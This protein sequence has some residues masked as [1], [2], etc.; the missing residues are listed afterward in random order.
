[1]L[2][3]MLHIFIL[4]R[5][6]RT[7]GYIYINCLWNLLFFGLLHCNLYIHLLLCM[8]NNGNDK[9]DIVR[10]SCRTNVACKHNLYCL[11]IFEL[12]CCILCNLMSSRNMSGN[13]IRK[14]GR[15][16]C[17]GYHHRNGRCIYRDNLYRMSSCLLASHS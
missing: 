9:V 16:D 13:Y 15:A 2:V 1:M 11:S 5:H 7:W 10:L 8:L 12:L 4:N 14:I 17:L 6:P 3:N